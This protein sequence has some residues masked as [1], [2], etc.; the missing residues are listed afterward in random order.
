MGSNM[1]KK[2]KM[3]RGAASFYVVAFSTLILV[4][5]ATSFATVILSEVA[6]SMNDDLSQSA[7][8]SA[9]AGIEDAK[10]AYANYR[11][12]LDAG[13]TAAEAIS[14]DGRVTC[15]EIIYWMR[16]PDC[17]M[18]GHILGRLPDN[19]PGGEVMVSDT[20]STSNGDVQNNLNQA[21][22][23]VKIMTELED[24][25]ATVSSSSRVR[26]LK[27][28]LKDAVASNIKMAELSWYAMSGDETLQ[29]QNLNSGLGRVAFMPVSSAPVATP[30]TVEL[31]MV[32]TANQFTFNDLVSASIGGKTDRATMYFVPTDDCALAARKDDKTYVGLQVDTCTWSGQVPKNEI[33]AA[34]IAKTNDE[35]IANLPFGV[36]CPRDG[37]GEFVCSVK[38]T[39]PEPIGGHGDGSVE[40]PDARNNDTFMMMVTLPYGQPDTD[41]SLRFY[42]DTEG[43]QPAI[44]D[45]AQ[46]QIDSTGRANDLFRRVEVRLE[47]SD[48]S[49]PYQY[50]AMELL[51]APNTTALEK[52]LTTTW[53]HN[54]YK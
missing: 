14:E 24:Y 48:V 54:D 39:L 33:S 37:T 53:E 12:C 50:Y 15:E 28:E 40:N 23:C 44:I 31:R 36:W 5:I 35:H 46:I 6:R 52:T 49:F 34:Q 30:P 20:I 7:Y 21:Y 25:R 22:T 4:I 17:D 45:G 2:I 51:G 27:V 11:R 10:L 47:S 3:V 19:E 32:Q 13:K 18:V 38:M 29:Y 8:D 43:E 16:H 26:V 42:K 1:K 9:L 41:F